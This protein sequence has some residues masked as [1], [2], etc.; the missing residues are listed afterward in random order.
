MLDL[1]YYEK[2]VIYSRKCTINVSQNNCY[3]VLIKVSHPI[4][5]VLQVA[6]KCHLTFK[7]L[8]TNI[9]NFL[10]CEFGMQCYCRPHCDH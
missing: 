2:N 10:D 5:S 4:S 6:V 9:N 7:T 3:F 8:N 1:Y